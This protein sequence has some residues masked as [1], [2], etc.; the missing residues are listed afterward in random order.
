MAISFEDYRRHDALG[1]ATAIARGDF[2]AQEVAQAALAR[3]RAV[4][5]LVG[6]VSWLDEALAERLC[7]GEPDPAAAATG[8]FAG[9]PYFI[10]DLHAPV[11]GVPLRH[12]SR[13]FDGQV[14]DFDSETV[15][16][17]R[18]AGL[19]ILG[20]TAA[21]EFG[22]N[23]STEPV[24]T[25]PTRNPWNLD[26]SAG[27]SSGGAAAAVAAGILPA[28]HATDSGGSIRIPASVTGL[29]GL[30]PT[31]GLIPTGPHR[32]DASHGMSHEHAV[33]RT[34]RDCAA[35]LDA[36]AGPDM[37]A[38][39]FTPRP[40]TPFLQAI[41]QPPRRLR[42]AFTVQDFTGAPVHPDCAQAV[43]SAAQRLQALGHAVETAAPAFDAPALFGASTKLLLTGLAAQV[44]AREQQLGRA[45][46]DDE[47]EPLTR[48]AVEMGRR[49]S[50]IEY[51]SQLPVF[52]TQVRRLAAF[53]EG[54]DVL[55]TPALAQPPARLGELHTRST[56]IEDYGRMMRRYT[57]FTGP[58]NATGQP[59][60]TLPLHW[61]AAGLP[62]GVQAVA[63]FGDDTTLLQLARELEQ[64]CGGFDRVAPL[65][66]PG[67]HA[68]PAKDFP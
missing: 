5:P 7:R 43:R 18:R 4:N 8:P 3:L 52:N 61:N 42:I 59:A 53:F 35:L 21:P 1:L 40:A 6:A 37:G 64:D 54:W 32:G 60:I 41:S 11:R 63:R 50:G 24:L 58:F 67:L 25:G 45:A 17:L 49:V 13:L 16:R 30:K 47:L 10:K 44:S 48:A 38:P 31:R 56:D 14:F 55:L 36:V 22:M 15:A 2:S 66:A 27:G 65:T 29:V 20:R 9:V 12:G 19:R 46:R 68:G 57:P 39:Y 28:A 26:H 51:T 33:T 34:V 62:I 23:V